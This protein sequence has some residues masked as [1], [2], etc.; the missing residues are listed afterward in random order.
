MSW[1]SRA[2]ELLTSGALDGRILIEIDTWEAD[3]H[4]GMLPR[5]MPTEGSYLGGLIYVRGFDVRGRILAPKELSG[6][7]I[8]VNLSPLAPDL[9]FIPSATNS[10]GRFYFR[11]ENPELRNNAMRL[12]IPEDDLTHMATRLAE[13]WKYVHVWISDKD[14]SDA[15]VDSYSFSATVHDDLKAWIAEAERPLRSVQSARAPT[16]R[17]AK[18]LLAS[19]AFDGRLL[20]EIEAWEANYGLGMAADDALAEAS[21]LDGLDLSRSFHLQGRVLA[22]KEVRGRTVRVNIF[23]LPPELLFVPGETTCVGR[24]YQK[25]ERPTISD[26]SM[27]VWIPEADVNHVGTC[28][29]T[30]WKYLHVW[31]SDPDEIDPDVTTYSFSSTVHRN[32]EAWVAEA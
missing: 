18:E 23:P 4:L 30:N 20:I 6:S 9:L 12:Y 11:P 8:D 26:H 27:T 32:L 19:S 22:P 15:G 16:R 17:R 3:F 10:V 25:P 7:T 29:A 28:L 5:G 14:E 31:I 1:N 21:Y 24:L 13:N 2:E